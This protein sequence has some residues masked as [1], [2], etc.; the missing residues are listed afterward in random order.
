M[1]AYYSGYAGVAMMSKGGADFLQLN[2]LVNNSGVGDARAL[3]LTQASIQYNNSQLLGILNISANVALGEAVGVIGTSTGVGPK[4]A[5][6]SNAQQSILESKAGVNF[7]E[8]TIKRFVNSQRTVN[9]L[10]LKRAIGTQAFPDPQG[11]GASAYYMPIL[12]NGKSYNLKVIYNEETNTIFHFH[13]SRQA[14][15]PLPK[16]KK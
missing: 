5:F 12:R 1:Q 2:R 9:A 6:Q 4:G 14:M 11:S 10:D 16:I 7:T 3:R 13:Y 15:G 8:T